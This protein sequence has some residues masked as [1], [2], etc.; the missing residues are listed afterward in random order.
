MRARL[1]C[2]L[3][4]TE[5]GAMLFGW[6]ISASKSLGRFGIIVCRSA[7]GHKYLLISLWRWSYRFLSRDHW[8]CV[9]KG[10][11]PYRCVTRGIV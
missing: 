6:D 9:F 5:P 10:R 11:R 8:D 1:H 2:S 7:W 3:H 4:R